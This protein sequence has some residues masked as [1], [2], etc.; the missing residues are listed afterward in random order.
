MAFETGFS[1]LDKGVILT[2]QSA[3]TTYLPY[4]AKL[5]RQQLHELERFAQTLVASR[6]PRY[7]TPFFS[8]SIVYKP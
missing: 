2:R 6:H 1:S 7:T 8:V 4:Q 3:Q 5:P